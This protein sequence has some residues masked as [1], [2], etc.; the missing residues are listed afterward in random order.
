[1]KK[2]SWDTERKKQKNDIRLLSSDDFFFHLK[3]RSYT[4]DNNNR[5]KYHLLLQIWCPFS[6][7]FFSRILFFFWWSF[8]EKKC[9]KQK[10]KG[11]LSKSLINLSLWLRMTNKQIKEKEDQWPIK[12]N[13]DT[14]K[15]KRINKLDWHLA[16]WRPNQNRFFFWHF[17]FSI[18][19]G[20]W[21]L[22][23]FF[24]YLSNVIIWF[25]K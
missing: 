17:I 3:I 14:D 8:S 20:Q 10:R 12:K 6:T 9:E 11:K 2:N 15:T 1:M 21:T 13:T 25:E 24:E 7:I 5:L 23:F 4:E 16:H 22:I 18:M 19:I